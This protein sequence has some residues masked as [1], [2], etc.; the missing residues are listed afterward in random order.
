MEN[1]LSFF[2]QLGLAFKSYG[3]AMSLLF[4]G[5]LW[6]Y[7]IYPIIISLLLFVAEFY[8]LNQL[9]SSY[10][11]QII[12]YFSSNDYP[13]WMHLLSGTLQYFLLIGLQVIFFLFFY[14]LG[15]YIVLILMSPIMAILSEK[16]ETL[17]TGK[18]YPFSTKQFFRDILRGMGI[19]LRNMFFQI[20]ILSASCI[21]I[22]IP[23]IGLLCPIFLLIIS[24]YFYGFSMLDYMSER[25]KLSVSE[26]IAFV[27]KNKGIAI[28]NG[29]IFT[30]LFAIPYIG[31]VLSTILSP[32]AACVS[33]LEKEN[34][35]KNS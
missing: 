15:K 25:R 20:V 31:I 18:K 19:A 29:F 32:I 35:L 14:F 7:I 6:L 24:Y 17:L 13:R 30:L 5:G 4:K 26:S 1:E 2:E 3:K 8:F 16:T 11:S 21:I 12:K 10:E 9:F 27:R 34:K 28:G 23:V 22:W 33:V